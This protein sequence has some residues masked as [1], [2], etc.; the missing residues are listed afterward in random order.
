M[1][2]LKQIWVLVFV[3]IFIIP[4]AGLTYTRH[5]CNMSGE[6]SLV[7]DVDYSC[8]VIP[9]EVPEEACCKTENT[10]IIQAD[11]HRT[12]EK[13]SVGS[14]E[15]ECCSNESK[16]LKQEDEYA[17]PGSIQLPRIEIIS[18]IALLADGPATNNLQIYHYPPPLLFK[19]K[20]IL[21][22]NSVLLI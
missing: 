14:E 6:T 12:S 1:K 15:K 7:L 17:A 9:E 10:S 18:T 4:A 21:L 16:Y 11:Q 2:V 22:R 5:T 13:C 20:D 19:H 3:V 8:C